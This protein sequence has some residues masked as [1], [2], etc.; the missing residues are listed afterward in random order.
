MP[1]SATPNKFIAKRW[2][3][4]AAFA[5]LFISA[6]VLAAVLM[7][8]QT[9][10]PQSAATSPS[11]IA[12]KNFDASDIV[13]F[14]NEAMTRQGIYEK[15]RDL[16]NA[17]RL[18]DA[19]QITNVGN[20][21]VNLKMQE[22]H[23][24]FPGEVDVWAFSVD[25]LGGMV[26]DTI[27]GEI[28]DYTF[29]I[30]AGQMLT[31]I[32]GVALEYF[33]SL[34]QLYEVTTMLFDRLTDLW[35]NLE[36]GLTVASCL[37]EAADRACLDGGHLQNCMNFWEDN[38]DTNK[39]RRV[40]VLLESEQ[41]ILNDLAA[42]SDADHRVTLER[43]LLRNW[44]DQTEHLRWLSPAKDFRVGRFR[45]ASRCVQV[46]GVDGPLP[47][48]IATATQTM[49]EF[50]AADLRRA[51]AKANFLNRSNLKLLADEATTDP[52][53]PVIGQQV[54]ASINVQ[55]VGLSEARDVVV[56]IS[57]VAQC[58]SDPCF[59][60]QTTVP[61]IASVSS[62]R[63][64]LTFNTAALPAGTHPVIIRARAP[65]AQS[66][67]QTF[68]PDTEHDNFFRTSFTFTNVPPQPITLFPPTLVTNSRLRLSWSRNNDAD[69]RRYNIYASDALPLGTTNIIGA[70]TSA[71][72]T[73]CEIPSTACIFTLNPDTRYYFQVVARD[74]LGEETSSNIASII[75]GVWLNAPSDSA[76]EPSVVT[77]L[78]ASNEP[79]LRSY[80]IAYSRD[81]NFVRDVRY[82][83]PTTSTTARIPGL[84]QGLRYYFKVRT[85][86]G[87]GEQEL[88]S[89]DSNIIN[90]TTKGNPLPEVEM[91]PEQEVDVGEWVDFNATVEDDDA[92]VRYEWDFNEDGTFDEVTTTPSARHRY[93]DVSDPGGYEVKMRAT[94]SEGA[95]G[96]D[97]VNVIISR[98]RN[99]HADIGDISF[100]PSSMQE[101]R[102]VTVNVSIHNNGQRP[103][104]AFWVGFKEDDQ[105]PFSTIGVASI[106]INGT[107]TASADHTFATAGNHVI[108]IVL[109]SQNDVPEFSE[110]DNTVA[111]PVSVGGTLKPDLTIVN[112]SRDIWI[113]PTNAAGNL[114]IVVK[115]RVSNRGAADALHFKVKFI[116][117]PDTPQTDYQIEVSNSSAL[118]LGDNVIMEAALDRGL[119]P[120][121]H[122]IGV[123]VDPLLQLDEIS[124]D[125]NY[126]ARTFTILAPRPDLEIRSEDVWFDPV[127]PVLGDNLTVYAKM[128]NVGSAPAVNSAA[129][130]YFLNLFW[131]GPDAPATTNG[132]PL[133]QKFINEPLAAGG[134]LISTISGNTSVVPAAGTY[135][136]CYSLDVYG[137]ITEISEDNNTACRTLTIYA[138]R[139]QVPASSRAPATPPSASEPSRTKVKASDIKKVSAGLVK[140]TTKEKRA[141]DAA[142]K[143]T[144]TNER[145]RI[146]KLKQLELKKRQELLRIRREETAFKA[147][148]KR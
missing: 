96:E 35:N 17:I 105:P 59:S 78:Y 100:T 19:Q 90:V 131:T 45:S 10:A 107:A 27:Y 38:S 77:F 73:T 128:R 114:P 1:Q 110:Q 123:A 72:T 83:A 137:A 11:T 94:D 93:T 33:S 127:Y 44:Q 146:Q 99:V 92:I 13:V 74:Q 58:G 7:R 81:Y 115:A 22:A 63:V 30:I 138:D 95:S 113:E 142:L 111:M 6:S 34:L 76:I 91:G 144:Q 85:V 82:L 140:R 124:E 129:P 28:F 132:R 65:I 79:T 141:E 87:L 32:A 9:P 116:S 24:F 112:P 68:H 64:D 88:V 103:S 51:E 55:N 147:K 136:I 119:P 36:T 122:T 148:T 53:Y 143:K 61:L 69:F 57:S 120:G 25:Q 16:F 29:E 109:D 12:Q 71:E 52:S 48:I 15:Y 54:V 67:P 43:R 20:I 84:E 126:A 8:A 62:Q 86:H 121:Q 46:G 18:G 3:V 23:S 66:N 47:A 14:T 56:D 70:V 125:N 98:L 135:N 4:T 37:D 106:Q 26:E 145:K 60:T 5:S 101:G 40:K 139:S 31:T 2:L 108:T 42:T 97:T 118:A 134:E 89:S 80:Q 104:G 75:T 117:D 130:Y 21:L 41:E 49:G 50:A 39:I 133:T 102:P